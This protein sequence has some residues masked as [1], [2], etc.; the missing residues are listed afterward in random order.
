MNA[1]GPLSRAPLSRRRSLR[2]LTAKWQN[3]RLT[4]AVALMTH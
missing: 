1:A 3:S 4:H 2:S